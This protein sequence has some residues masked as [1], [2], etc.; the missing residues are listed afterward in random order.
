MGEAELQVDSWSSQCCFLSQAC[1]GDSCDSSTKNQGQGKY[2]FKAGLSYIVRSCLEKG[3]RKKLRNGWRKRERKR[4]KEDIQDGR[5]FH[6]A[7]I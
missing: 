3:K 6:T 4:R 1:W 2:Q 5:G 7:F